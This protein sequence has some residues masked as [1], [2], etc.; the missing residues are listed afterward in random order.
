VKNKS[1]MIEW[2]NQYNGKMNCYYTIY[3]F[4]FFSEKEKIESSVIKDRAFLDLDAHGDMSL[5]RAYLDLQLLARNFLEQDILFQM[6]FSGKGFHVIVHG[7]IANEIRQI[8]SWYRYIKENDG[9]V[10][11]S[12]DDS[13]IQTNRLRRI[14]NT[15]NLSSSDENGEPYF[16]I[17]ILK[18]DLDKPLEYITELAKKP[19]LVQSKYGTKLVSWPKVKPMDMSDI[20]IEG[21][22]PINKLPIIPCLLNAI[23]VQNPG[24]YARVYL[25]QWYRD[26]LTMG[27]KNLNLEQKKGV[28]ETIM[29]ELEHIASKDDVWLDWDYNKTKNYVWGIVNKGYNAPS[30]YNVLIPQGYCVGKCWRYHE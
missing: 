26:I 14:P 4:T 25:V 13:G 9:Y 6:Y 1:E 15:V 20:E 23:M 21:T 19:R 8:Q 30:C 22:K 11:E 18:E 16:C 5:S 28:A 17:P 7:E 10:L 12:L 24:H 2:I 29:T 3:D 27:H